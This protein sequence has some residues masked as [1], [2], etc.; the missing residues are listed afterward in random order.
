MLFLS[1]LFFPLVK[2]DEDVANPINKT[3]L[4]DIFA[5]RAVMEFQISPKGKMSLMVFL[6]PTHTISFSFFCYYYYLWACFSI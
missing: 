4:Q 3:R 5:K 2:A 1:L 6:L